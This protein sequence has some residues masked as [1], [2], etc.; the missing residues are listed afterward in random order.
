MKEMIPKTVPQLLE[1]RR[2]EIRN[3][4][5]EEAAR[6]AETYIRGGNE[7]ALARAIATAIRA[8]KD[9]YSPQQD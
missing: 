4:A 9:N 3:A 7:E 8:L 2:H 1:M 6:I 5:L